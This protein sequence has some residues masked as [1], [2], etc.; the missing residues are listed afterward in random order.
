MKKL[1]MSLLCVA[2]IVCFMP[3]M[4]WADTAT[5]SETHP[6][7]NSAQC[8]NC[9]ASVTTA[10]NNTEF[11]DSLE[12][13][14]QNVPTDGTA[15]KIT[16]LKNIKL[17]NYVRINENRNI[18]M[19]LNG[20]EISH[21]G[22][23]VFI[24][25]KAKV[26]FTG[27]GT[28]S[29][30]VVDGYAPIIAKGSAT[31]TKEYTVITIDK[32]VQLKGD[33]AGIFVDT[34]ENGKGSYYNYGLVINMRGTIDLSQIGTTEPYGYAIYVQGNHTNTIG[35]VPKIN[36][37]GAH[38]IDGAE[39]GIYAAGYADWDIKNSDISG[40][41]GIEVRAGRLIVSDNALITGTAI[42]TEVT[43]NGNG[44]TTVGAGIAIAQHTTKLPIDVTINGGTISGYSALYQSNPQ[45]NDDESVAKVSVKVNGGEYKAI[46]GGNVSVYSENKTN[47][48]SAGTFSSNPKEYVAEG[49]NIYKYNDTKFVVSATA[50][51]HSDGKN[52]WIE[53]KE[54]G[55][56]TET[57]VSYSSGSATTDNVTNKSENTTTGEAA[58][59][60]AD[61][62]ASTTTKA[63]GTKTT[64][65]TVDNTTAGK[66]VDKA[67]ANKS[68]EVVVDAT[69]T[70]AAPAAG[71]TTEV[72]LPEKTVQD[73][74]AKT[75]ANVT[76]KTDAASVAL[77]KEAVDAV[78]A[79]AG[80]TGT[81]KLVVE[82]V[83]TDADIHQVELKLVTSNGA[84]TDFKGGNV[85]VTIKLDAALNA[86]DVVCVYIDDNGVYHKVNGQKNADGTY[87]FT[88]GHFSAYAVMSTE[89]A[90][91]VFAQQD[92]KAA[93]LTKAL[94]LQA[95][96]AKTSKG[97]I[98]VTLNVN[99]D[100]IKALEDLGYTVKYKYYRST[101]KAAKYTAKVE[102]TEKTYTNTTGK[103][104][105]RYYYKARVMVYGAD[106]QLAAKTALN[107]CKYACRIK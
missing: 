80:T 59:T 51:A 16:I 43:P 101:V 50:P 20:H 38:I 10:E 96:S 17:S 52:T 26:N 92:A 87:T 82:T 12:A 53:D 91:K 39:T 74:A 98:K 73:L 42:P 100:D 22:T 48:I 33:Y 75:D 49:T 64:T 37:D 66:I 81:V 44:A 8:V 19:D 23:F 70:A 106:G 14:I 63:D 60:T 65:A 29:E 90:E 58:S 57:Y 76:I 68:E 103:K 11:F 15:T 55:Y 88:T 83:K 18:T 13:A 30:N 77:D 71:T 27:D 47:F 9:V 25:C 36:L 107:Q 79:Q 35:N 62:N 102:K 40:A 85:A 104:G 69:S 93:D 99:A 72:A 56:Y 84:V 45:K 34:D 67:V 4:A 86:K 5:L 2:M 21:D 6:D 54:N 78:A 61:I 94:K 46:N 97:N 24:I 41:T 3:T 105:T 32:N 1:L 89:E 95:R 31:D 7:N 28:I